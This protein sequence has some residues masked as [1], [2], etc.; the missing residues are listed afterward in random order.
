MV[1]SKLLDLGGP[2]RGLH[3]DGHSSISAA[4]LLQE[5]QEADGKLI[6]GHEHPAIGIS[7]G[8]AHYAK[9]PCFLASDDWL[10]LPAFSA[11][12]A[13]GDVRRGTYLSAFPN[14]AAPNKAV[15][16]LAGKLLPIPLRS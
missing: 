15:A 14:V 9:V 13:G 1:K 16:I 8:V 2:R 4:A 3:G 5:A 7:D 6:L 10:V 11:W 12:A